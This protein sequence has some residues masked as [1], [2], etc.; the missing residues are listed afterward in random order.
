MLASYIWVC[1]DYGIDGFDIALV[2]FVITLLSGLLMVSNFRYKSFKDIDLKGKVPFVAILLVVLIFVF[3]SI[4]P[5]I[6][7]FVMAAIYA[8]SGP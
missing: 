7:L 4:D 2:T 5:P 3:V 1:N 8:L 6:I